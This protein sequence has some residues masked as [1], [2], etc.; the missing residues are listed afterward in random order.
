MM[1]SRHIRGTRTAAVLGIAGPGHLKTKDEIMKLFQACPRC[2]AA[3]APYAPYLTGAPKGADE[4]HGPW[5]RNC[6][7]RFGDRLS[8][9]SRPG[10]HNIPAGLY[11]R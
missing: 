6:D 2:G 10:D 4:G 8:R 1:E 11:L 7:I 3:S 5:C 9:V